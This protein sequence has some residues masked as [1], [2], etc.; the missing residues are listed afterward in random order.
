MLIVVGVV[1]GIIGVVAGF[2]KLVG[3]EVE[4]VVG[5]TMVQ[6]DA[7]DQ[8]AIYRTPAAFEG[9]CTA[10][11]PDGAPLTAQPFFGTETLTLGGVEYVVHQVFSARVTGEQAVTCSGNGF[12][13]G[14]R[15]GVFGLVGLILSGI[16]GGLAVAGL[17]TILLVI[18][19]VRRKPP[20]TPAPPGVWPQGPPPGP[21][22]YPGAWPQQGPPTGPTP[23]PG[24][25][26]SQGPPHRMQ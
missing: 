10:V 4:P 12:A 8:F 6:V 20:R 15:V 1:L 9:T 25:W 17:G 26:P 13:V 24:S 2:S 3:I 21:A 14:P 19:I 11:G 7:G 16:F 5:T 22:P 23:Q 18:G